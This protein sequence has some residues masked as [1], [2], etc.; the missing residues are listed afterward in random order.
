M[1]EPA[2][3]GGFARH[4]ARGSGG[5]VEGMSERE[6]TKGGRA[7]NVRR[8]AVHL[9]WLAALAVAIGASWRG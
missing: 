9:G 7:V 2:L 8:I 1:E 6:L 3:L 4:A 5:E